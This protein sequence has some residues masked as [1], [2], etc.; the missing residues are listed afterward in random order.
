MCKKNF[1]HVC[2]VIDESGSMGGTEQDVIGGF[3]KV[4]DEQ[5]ENKEGS[6]SVSYYK[7]ASNVEKVFIGKDVNEVEYLDGKYNPGGLTALF[8]GVGTAID[9]IGKWLDS[10]DEDEKPEKNVIVIMTDGGENNSKEY[11]VSQVKEMIKHQ[12]EKYDWTFVYMGSD[13][14]NA[15]DANSLGF[16]TRCFS[17]KSDYL[18]NYDMINA[19]VTAYRNTVGEASLKGM[20][21]TSTLNASCNEA[22]EKYAKENNLDVDSL[23]ANND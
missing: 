17:S 21:F 22:T 13:L 16:A 7:F 5:K 10:M 9:E 3:K 8:D 15:N 12:E 2:F 19:S 4:V 1:V 20:A 14:S 23:T 18:S 11:T 6:C